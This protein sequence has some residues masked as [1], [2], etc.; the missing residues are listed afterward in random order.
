VVALDEFMLEQRLR[1]LPRQGR[2]AFALLL[3]ERMIPALYKFA[4]EADFD[5]SI[6][7]KCLNGAWSCL[8]RGRASFDDDCVK[9]CLEH[10]PETEDYNHL[11]T[12]AALNS[13]LSIA[14]MMEYMADD[15]V[16]HVVESAGLAR[17]TAA[18]YAQEM[19]AVAPRSL[20]FDEV[21]THTLVLRELQQQADDLEFVEA[22]PV[23]IPQAAIALVKERAAT[24][25]ALLPPGLA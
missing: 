10:A 8:D 17:D 3:N 9:E 24:M 14:A 11:L 2:L 21:M 19:E 16:S 18:S 23:D 12:S 25:P 20:S 6:Y 13:A 1:R 7:R 22:L 5:S 4:N 15:D